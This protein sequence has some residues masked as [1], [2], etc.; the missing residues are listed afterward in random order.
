MLWLH[1]SNYFI[2]YYLIPYQVIY[3]KTHLPHC[4]IIVT[5]GRS[6]GRPNEWTSNTTISVR[7]VRCSYWTISTTGCA[8]CHGK[9]FLLYYSGLPNGIL[10]TMMRHQM[11]LHS[12]MKVV[13]VLTL[14]QFTSLQCAI[15]VFGN[16]CSTL[17]SFVLNMCWTRHC[18]FCSGLYNVAT[19]HMKPVSSI[20]AL[21]LQ[22]S[23]T[24]EASIWAYFASI[25]CNCVYCFVS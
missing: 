14:L 6:L 21:S 7:K 20:W 17:L 2:Y 9:Q 16:E 11:S 10:V 13:S 22:C 25:V 3:V 8:A 1:I 12:T 4:L 23:Y 24:H 18:C 5:S 15:F 19:Q